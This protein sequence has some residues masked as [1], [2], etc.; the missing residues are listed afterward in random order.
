MPQPSPAPSV[1][2][3]AG[4]SASGA[5]PGLGMGMGAPY[6]GGQQGMWTIRL[7]TNDRG[8]PGDGMHHGDVGMN[9]GTP[10]W[11]WMWLTAR[12]LGK[13]DDA[14]GA[15]RWADGRHGDDDGVDG[16]GPCPAAAAVSY[17]VVSE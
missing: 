16:V 2:S 14:R 10:M 4:G 12:P 7:M 3:G 13:R 8:G 1:A 6:A 5:P 11:V 15:S 17:R 9:G